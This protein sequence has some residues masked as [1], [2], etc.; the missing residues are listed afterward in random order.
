MKTGAAIILLV[1]L[2][3]Y[4]YPFLAMMYAKPDAAARAW[5]YALRGME[6]AVLF[7]FV[8]LMF[9]HVYAIAAAS[10][11][12]FAEEAQTSLCRLA[13]PMDQPVQAPLVGGLC[14]TLGFPTWEVALGLML[15][16][17]VGNRWK[18]TT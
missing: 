10:W 1:A 17:L 7:S 11:W 5:F 13:H 12:G 8:A 4:G 9:R 14:A 18:T 3:H 6:G 16:I 2:T 15:G